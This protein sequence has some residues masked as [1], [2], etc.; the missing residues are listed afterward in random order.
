MD[1]HYVS[2]QSISCFMRFM[3]EITLQQ[4][5]NYMFS[6]YMSSNVKFI[7]C[8]LTTDVAC[9]ILSKKIF[10]SILLNKQIQLVKW[11][12]NRRVAYKIWIFDT[13]QIIL[14]SKSCVFAQLWYF[15]SCLLN[16]S[17]VLEGLWQ[18]LH[19]NSGNR[20]CLASMCLLTSLILIQICPQMLQIAL[21]ST[22][23]KFCSIK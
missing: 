21:L 17:L 22:L 2:S 16:E 4:W 6:F 18:I 13:K 11:Q 19:S 5:N 8:N 9:P 14:R 23:P 10:G 15:I 20:T 3:A 12:L 1:F 7:D